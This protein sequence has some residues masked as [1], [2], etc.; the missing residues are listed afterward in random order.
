[1]PDDHRPP[2]KLAEDARHRNR[3]YP[4]VSVHD[5]SRA[6]AFLDGAESSGELPVRCAATSREATRGVRTA[7]TSPRGRKSMSDRKPTL[8]GVAIIGMAGRFPSAGSVKEFWRNQLN[9]VESISHFTVDQLEV[10]NAPEL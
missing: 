1:F 7:E 4:P 9:G 2:R 8:D 5:D 10:P 6:G 3:D